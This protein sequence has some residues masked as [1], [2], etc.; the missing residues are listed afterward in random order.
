MKLAIDWTAPFPTLAP[1]TIDQDHCVGIRGCNRTDGYVDVKVL[2]LFK[3]KGVPDPAVLAEALPRRLH[4]RS[5]PVPAGL[6]GPC[7]ATEHIP[8]E[9]VSSTAG[10]KREQKPSNGSLSSSGTS[11]RTGQRSE[12]SVLS[13]KL[14]R[15]GSSDTLSTGSSRNLNR[16]SSRELKDVMEADCV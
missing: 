12:P 1:C 2:G 10:F 8:A 15:K 6:V 13:L 5:F 11:R 16:A 14:N 4:S 3:L 7:D 9:S